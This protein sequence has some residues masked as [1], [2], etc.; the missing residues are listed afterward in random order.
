MI[1]LGEAIGQSVANMTDSLS[2][3]RHCSICGQLIP[4]KRIEVLGMVR[5]VQPCCK[6]EA[7]AYE[8]EKREREEAHR[9][10]MI[11]RKFAIS[12]LGERFQNSK[13]DTF[14]WRPGTEKALQHAKEFVE[15]FDNNEGEGLLIWGVSGNGKSHLAAAI[16]HALK[17]KEKT[18][19]FQD[20][21]ELLGRIRDTFN[22]NSKETETA[23]MDALLDCN[24]LVMDDIG[25]EKVTDWVLD[26]LFRIIDGRNRRMKPI[27][28]TTNFNPAK[29][30]QRFM[31]KDEDMSE[32]Q[33]KRIVDRITGNSLIIENKGTSYRMEQARNRHKN[34]G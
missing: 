3:P 9:K 6:C 29:L 2:E 21:P 32:I 30:L 33:A 4:K 14:D 28:Y 26:V 7:E 10:E 23:I 27:V 34:G 18:V 17:A 8:Q 22:R 13:F 15:N 24:L 31:T 25:A 5:Y 16:V 1:H 19:V 20:V 12:K 11:E